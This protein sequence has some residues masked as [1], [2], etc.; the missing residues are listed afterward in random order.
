MLSERCQLL[1]R[2]PRASVACW[3]ECHVRRVG[4][5]GW[6][7]VMAVVVGVGVLALM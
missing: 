3:C 6:Q 2:V 7:V 1:V 4:A 5:M